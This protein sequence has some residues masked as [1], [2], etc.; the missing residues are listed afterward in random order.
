MFKTGIDLFLDL[1]SD[2]GVKYIFGN[3]GSTELPLNDALTRD[4]RLK[5]ILGLQEVP[6]LSLIHI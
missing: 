1:L 3:P 6:V 2:H 4:A 5:Y